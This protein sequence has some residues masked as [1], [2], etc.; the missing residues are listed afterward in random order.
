MERGTSVI[1]FGSPSMETGLPACN[2][3]SKCGTS[4]FMFGFRQCRHEIR[5][6]AWHAL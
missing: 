4:A 2:L 5:L 1:E 3:H 6:Q